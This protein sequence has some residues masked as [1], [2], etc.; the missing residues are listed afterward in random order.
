MLVKLCHY[1]VQNHSP[2]LFR[3]KAHVFKWSQSRCINLSHYSHLNFSCNTLLTHIIPSTLSS[4][5]RDNTLD[6]CSRYPENTFP[7]SISVSISPF[8]TTIKFQEP[9]SKKGLHQTFLKLVICLY[10]LSL[11]F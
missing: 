8:F 2:T 11:T 5:N 9:H 4:C 7:G 1:S 3:A 10:P 6:G